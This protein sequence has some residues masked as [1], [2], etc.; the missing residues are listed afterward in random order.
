MNKI[1][2]ALLPIALAASLSCEAQDIPEVDQKAAQA[3]VAISEGRGAIEFYPDPALRKDETR[4]LSE[5]FKQ[6]PVEPVDR[7][8][9]L[10]EIGD[11]FLGRGPIRPG[12]KTPTGQML[13]PWFLLFGSMRSAFQSFDN[14]RQTNVEW[15]NRLDLHGNLNLSGTERILFSMRPLDNRFGDFTGYRFNPDSRDG[16]QSD[17]NARLSQFFFE[18]DF[19]EIF[20]GLDPD[21]SGTLDFGFSVGRQLILVQN[22]LLLNDII[23][24]FGVTRNSLVLPGISNLRVTG[25]FAWDHVHRGNN[26]LPIRDIDHTVKLYGLLSEADTALNNT[27]NFDLIYAHEKNDESAWYVGA[28]STQRIAGYNTTFRVNAS[29]PATCNSEV[30]SSGAILQSQI[31]KT[32]KGSDNLLYFNTFWN[33]DRFT[34]AA[35]GPNQGLPVSNL[36][37]L[38]APVGIGSYG[39]ALGNR[40]DSTV[41]AALGY[42]MFFDGI[43][44][45]LI[46]EVG[47]RA[48]TRK[49]RDEAAAGLGARFEKTI[50]RRHVLRFDSFVAGAEGQNPSFGIRSEWMI[51]F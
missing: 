23:D 36:G 50:G 19:G 6:Y 10:L 18:G 28:S 41:G 14:G 29:I 45:Q 48:S 37:I 38:Y 51:K 40:I 2:R 8:R 7:L 15:A 46:L 31:S 13:Q 47:A 1:R 44:S 21:D 9:P 32:L 20:P 42:Q 16:W 3:Q 43:N 17:F 49:H 4:R 39:V 33:I 26:D 27:L 12:V 22:G 24:A 5:D 30:A 34:S 25:L 11:P 35:R